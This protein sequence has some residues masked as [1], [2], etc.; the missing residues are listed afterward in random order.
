MHSVDSLLLIIAFSFKLYNLVHH[1]IFWHFN[2]WLNW[3]ISKIFQLWHLKLPVCCCCHGLSTRH[4]WCRGSIIDYRQSIMRCS[5][6]GIE[7]CLSFNSVLFDILL[8]I[9][10]LKLFLTFGISKEWLSLCFH[11]WSRCDCV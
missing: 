8:L 4:L 6:G 10:L 2:L 3:V 11:W 7:A 1:L 5:T 9:H